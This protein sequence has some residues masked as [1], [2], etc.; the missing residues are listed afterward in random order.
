MPYASW[1]S[2]SQNRIA[3]AV[4]YLACSAESPPVP[5]AGYPK[6]KME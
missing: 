3:L 1:L 6:V 5:P 4:A 2:E